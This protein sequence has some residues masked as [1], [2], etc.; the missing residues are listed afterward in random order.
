MRSPS[1]SARPG[2]QASINHPIDPADADYIVCLTTTCGGET[3]DISR[4]ELDRY[5]AFISKIQLTPA[6]WKAQHRSRPCTIH[7]KTMEA[8]S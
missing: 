5:N 8:R 6:D 7:A 3:L 4:P 1:T 2:A